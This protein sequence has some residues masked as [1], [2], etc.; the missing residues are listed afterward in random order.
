MKVGKGDLWEYP[1]RPKL[2]RLVLGDALSLTAAGFTLAE[3]AERKKVFL[4][5]VH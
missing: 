5:V 3:L 4:T 1:L 2:Y